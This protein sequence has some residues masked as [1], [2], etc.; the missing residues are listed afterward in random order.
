MKFIHQKVAQMTTLFIIISILLSCSKDSDLLLDAVLTETEVSVEEKNKLEEKEVE[1]SEEGLVTRTF[2]FTPTNDAYLQDEQGHNQSIIRLQED[3]RTSYLMFDLSQVNGTITE[4]VLQFS[5]DS[6]EGD[7]SIAIHKGQN[8]DWTEESL[9]LNNAPA[10]DNQLG[11]INKSYK[12][13]AP[14]KIALTPSSLSSEVTTLIM[15]HASGNDLAFASKEHPADKGPKLIITYE[16]AADSPLIEQQ[17]EEQESTTQEEDTTQ[18]AEDTNQQEDNTQ[19]EDDLNNTTT[20]STEGAKYVTVNGKAT[21][22]GNS[23]GSAWSIEHAFD[24]AIAGDVVYVKAGD[25]GNKQLIAD[26]SGTSNEPIKFIG[27]T[28]TPGD[29]TS[30]KG[31][32]FQYG[33]ILNKNIMPLLI[34][35]APNNEGQGTGIL[36]NENYI[37]IENFQITKFETGVRSNGVNIILK[38]IIATKIGDFNPAH[39]YPSGTS[40]KFLNYSGNGIVLS[41]NRSELH[42]SFILNC[43]AQGITFNNGNGIVANNNDVY[44]DNP[45]NPT[46]YYF[47]I[48]EETTNSTFNN[49]T[50]H[51]VGSLEHNGHGIVLKGNGNI[52]GNTI[53]GFEIINTFLELQFPKTSNNTAKN[54]TITKESNVDINNDI[55]GGLKLANGSHHNNFRNIELVNCSILFQD[56]NDGLNGDVNDASDNNLFDK[57]TVKNANSA[58][59]FSFFHVN[60]LE[61]SADNNV[62]TNCNFNNLDYLF[63]RDRANSGTKLINCSINN[64]DNFAQQRIKDGTNYS[65]NAS[66]ENCTW[67]NIGFT[68][69]N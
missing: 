29:L 37:T 48:A 5:I 64:V 24:R 50:V 62:F 31:S 11:S 33:D 68:P 30:D 61:S 66:Y 26:N 1:V 41:G 58:I 16:T 55:V 2:T 32:T 34:G 65:I 49:T 36:I 47:L 13:G 9:D 18:E 10:L 39:T 44:A 17:E 56:W 40:N 42:N 57:I 14:E 53:D 4:A 51:R 28:N 19:Q 20:A 22:D 21:N 35:N 60:N 69:P 54:G 63:E 8:A 6:D 7:G 59:S 43:G 12:I 3:F 15:K 67:A 27:Y 23:E 52:S 46:D 45:A 25:Y 38:N